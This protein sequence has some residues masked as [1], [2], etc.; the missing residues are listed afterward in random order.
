MNKLLAMQ[1]FCRVLE[2]AS[3]AQA[4]RELK[5]SSAQVSKHISNLEQHLGTR[6]LNRTTRKVTPTEAGQH[7]YDQCQQLLEQLDLLEHSV[8]DYGRRPQGTLKIS[9]P[10]DFGYLYLVPLVI[11]YQQQFPDV[12]IDLHLGDQQV[13]LIEEGFDIALRISHLKDSSLVAR[14]LAACELGYFAS[15]E[16]LKQAGTP[17]HP[18]QLQQHR[19]LNYSYKPEPDVW[20]FQTAQGIQRQRLPW[21]FSCNNGRALCEAA[22]MGQGIIFKPDFLV[23]SYLQEGRLVEILQDYR[24]PPVGIYAVY[25]HRR[26]VPQKITSFIDF[27]AQ[28]WQTQLP[29]QQS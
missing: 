8:T 13:N 15:P 18:E 2:Y 11:A 4:A 10:M 1:V 14:K 7:Y 27:L 9:A 5:L 21:Q 28:A 19:C 23:S 17:T 20:L 3:F 22:A 29:W 24:V 26:F 6:L 16:Y 25:L 12:R